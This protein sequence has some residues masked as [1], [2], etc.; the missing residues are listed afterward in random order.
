MARV[1]PVNVGKM[2]KTLV[3]AGWAAA[4]MLSILLS[5][6]HLGAIALPGC[7]PADG[8]GE[9]A[10]SPWATIPG[11]GTSV[12]AAGA[13]VF[14]GLLAAAWAVRF[15]STQG[16]RA[17]AIALAAGS[18]FYLGV[19]AGE[20]HACTYCLL[21]HAA[22][23]VAVVGVFR[24]ARIEPVPAPKPGRVKGGAA[25]A[26]PTR[27]PHALGLGLG[28]AAT[29]L[30]AGV[31][32]EWSAKSATRQE[33]EK[34]LTETIAK[35]G[36]ARANTAAA[37]APPTRESGAKSASATRFEGRYRL[38][39]ESSPIR[40][41]MFTD[42]QCS[43]C[44]IME[45]QLD[46]VL[47]NHPGVAVSIKQ[48]PI[49]TYCNPHVTEDMHPDACFGAFAAEAAGELA[50]ADAF[51]KMHRWLFE[52]E[53]SFTP[54]Q[55]ATQ[56][57]ALGLDAQRHRALVD[58]A[59][60]RSRVQTDIKE[61]VALG[62]THTPMIFINGVELKGWMAPMALVRAVDQLAASSPQSRD[63]GADTPPNARERAL[64]Q[65]RD[66]PRVTLP[67][68]FKRRWLGDADATIEVVLVG[69]YSERGVA[70]GDAL[71]R[72]YTSDGAPRI[73]YNFVH[74]PVDQACNPVVPFTKNDRSCA[75]ARFAEAADLIAGPTAFW[76]VHEWLI[77]NQATMEHATLE[78]AAP[79]AGTDQDT[80]LA[81]VEDAWVR[82]QIEEDAK[83]AQALG[84]ASLP[85]IYV[86]GKLVGV[87]KLENENLLPAIL[88]E[89]AG[90][91][92]H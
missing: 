2:A 59:I 25:P 52:M 90:R 43:D 69:D 70:E 78:G 16:L 88:A 26:Q 3:V 71:L 39:P 64:S 68:R 85:A 20:G 31:G 44:K 53:G 37:K 6:K 72:M 63:G 30:A 54:D 65:W 29:V 4:I 12:A 38:G 83:A 5:F 10:K 21:A 36:D 24:L 56:V 77:A 74:Y 8:C 23:A 89:A 49:S 34:A 81:A 61:G 87:W 82:T 40:I 67:E 41:V 42:Y 75:A 47:R 50:G 92:G 19:M 15:R 33:A 76:R 60:V 86:D 91:R 66:A 48:F 14:A 13:A 55:L 46:I 32:L 18:V 22:N 62:I 73:R 35:A 45:Q 28:V 7:G 27:R 11:I 79:L 57:A 1:Q 80:M 51:W 9:L 58:D 84:I 17:A